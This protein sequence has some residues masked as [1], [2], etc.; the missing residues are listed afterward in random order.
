MPGFFHKKYF[1]ADPVRRKSSNHTGMQPYSFRKFTEAQSLCISMRY[2]LPPFVGA[3]H[4]REQKNN[5][6]HGPVTTLPLL[7]QIADC[8]LLV[9]LQSID[10]ENPQGKVSSGGFGSG[11]TDPV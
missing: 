5:R 4:A 10:T 7:Q 9:L 8:L 3:G 2:L 11:A 1:D 6:G